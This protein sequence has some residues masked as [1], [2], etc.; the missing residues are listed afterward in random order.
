MG[1]NIAV[2]GAELQLTPGNGQ[3]SISGVTSTKVKFDGKEAYKGKISFSISAYSGPNCTVP[4]SGSGSGD[5][6]GSAQFV[7]VEGEAVVLEGDKVTVQVNGKRQ[8]GQTQVPAVDSV[9][10]TVVDASQ[11]SA[12]AV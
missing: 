11:S 2:D 12:K 6:E 9:T 4:S 1:K 10:V 7:K 3:I 8:A 5:I